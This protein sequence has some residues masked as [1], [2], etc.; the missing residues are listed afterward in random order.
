MKN[1]II[2]KVG[3][4]L[5]LIICSFFSFAQEKSSSSRVD[6]S[7]KYK[8]RTTARNTKDNVIKWLK[9]SIEAKAPLK[10][11][12]INNVLKNGRFDEM[13]VENDALNDILYLI[14]PMK[15]VY[16]SQHIDKSKQLPLQYLVVTENGKGELEEGNLI[17]IYPADKDLQKLPKNAIRNYYIQ[18]DNA[19][20]GTYALITLYCGDFKSIEVD[21]KNGRQVEMRGYPSKKVATSVGTCLEWSFRT[22]DYNKD[23]L[24]K[25]TV[26]PLGISCTVCPPGF[27][28]DPLTAIKVVSP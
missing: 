20:D 18:N 7:N 25:E 16:F 3:I 13:Y 1:N 28:C 10:K 23:G 2:K 15:K 11:N 24:V 4:L 19:T 12:M 8:E 26:K 27:K 17:L 14:V 21:I 9:A 6:Y 5:L 22:T